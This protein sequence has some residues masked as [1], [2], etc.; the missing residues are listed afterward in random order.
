ML[1]RPFATAS[2]LLRVS[3]LLWSPP[4]CY[5]TRLLY[6]VIWT[7]DNNNRN[8]EVA[9]RNDSRG[10]GGLLLLWAAVT[11]FFVPDNAPRNWLQS[12]TCS[13]D[14]QESSSNRNDTRHRS[15]DRD[16]QSLDV[17]K[18]ADMVAFSSR[19]IAAAR[20][21]ESR[22]ADRLF[23]DYFAELLVSRYFILFLLLPIRVKWDKGGG[24]ITTSSAAH[25]QWSV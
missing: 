10:E 14:I 22:R 9:W 3:I 2:R 1:C 5:Y 8:G 21:V 13:C 11:L 25:S 6:S 16:F 23:N 20:A 24:I 12:T 18:K 7:S 4:G 17:M 15:G 19:R